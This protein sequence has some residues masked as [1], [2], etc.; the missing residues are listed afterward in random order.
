M[1][2]TVVAQSGNM[3]KQQQRRRWQEGW[4]AVLPVLT[5]DEEGETQEC[6][7]QVKEERRQSRRLRLRKCGSH[8]QATDSLT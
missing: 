2:E 7:Q 4:Q 6:L 3:N 8:D 5:A 1:H